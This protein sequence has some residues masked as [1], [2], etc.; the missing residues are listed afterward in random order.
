M[1]IRDR[2][3]SKAVSV[4]QQ[5]EQK[6]TL[7][8]QYTIE[9]RNLLSDM[10][11]REEIRTFLFK[12]WAEVLAVANLRDGAKDPLTLALKKTA[13]DLVWSASAKPNRADRTK[14]IQ[15][16]PALLQRLRQ[17]LTLLGVAGPCLL[18]TSRCV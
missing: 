4:A 10:P 1:C 5:I 2:N 16:L 3:T 9:M 17:G 13:T 6:E 12:T 11:M 15:G 18:Y 7:T 14:V 8:I